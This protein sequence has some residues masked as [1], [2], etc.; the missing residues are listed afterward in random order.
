MVEKFPGPGESASATASDGAGRAAE[1]NSQKDKTPGSQG[2]GVAKSA[3][4][5]RERSAKELEFSVK[6]AEEAVREA[7]PQL[8]AVCGGPP[9]RAESDKSMGPTPPKKPKST[10][11]TGQERSARVPTG[12][13]SQTG[14]PITS[15]ATTGQLLGGSSTDARWRVLRVSL[16][17]MISRTSKIEVMV[18]RRCCRPRRVRLRRVVKRQVQLRLSSNRRDRPRRVA[19]VCAACRLPWRPVS[20][21]R[22]PAVLT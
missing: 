18:M 16:G 3:S 8:A 10:F 14:G 15:D 21:S 2:Q 4:V 19:L 22:F 9:A 12:V 20:E 5:S 7:A 11:V 13:P 6:A 1:E 17:R